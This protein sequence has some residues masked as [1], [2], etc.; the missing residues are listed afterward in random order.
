MEYITCPYCGNKIDFEGDVY[1]VEVET[2]CDV[3]EKSF[4]VTV[5]ITFTYDY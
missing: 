2:Y 1:G 3:C 4:L 5:T